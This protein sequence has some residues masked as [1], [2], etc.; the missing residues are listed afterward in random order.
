M[1][2]YGGRSS[3]RLFDLAR[4]AL[5]G[6]V[7]SPVRAFGPYPWFVHSAS[8]AEVKS[9]EG[10]EMVDFVLGYG[11]L[12]LGHARPEVV[13]A[14]AEQAKRGTLFGAP[15]EIE[16]EYAQ[17]IKSHVPGAERVRCV[18]T[19]AEAT[20]CALR[21]AR[22]AK[23]KDVIVKFDGGFHGAHDAVMVKGGSGMATHGVPTSK[24]VPKAVAALTRVIPSNDEA[25]LEEALKKE[26]VAAVIAEPVMANIGVVTP[27]P[28]FLKRLRAETRKRDAML[29]FDEVV[30]GFRLAMGGAQS[31]Y[32]VHADLVALG[33][34]AG[35]GLPIGVV[36][37]PEETMSLISPEGE[38][39]NAGTFNGNPLSMAAGLA[40]LKELEAG[41]VHPH[42]AKLT[43]QMARGLY[44][45][46][47]DRREEDERFEACVNAVTGMLTMF[48]AR[49]VK[50]A[51][52]ARAAD[53]KR[54]LAFHRAMI[55]EGFWLP[56]SQFEAW[57][58]SAAHT[59]DQVDRFC[60]VAGDH[61]GPGA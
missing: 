54:Y 47:D 13:E 56:P 28:G 26:D 3:K 61:I 14:I 41:R 29:V 36:A 35:G 18:N 8:G 17:T 53:A 60:E 39:Y 12:V 4:E 50:D 31:F 46:V 43:E 22:A 6:G 2:E 25:A 9:V 51:A 19:G 15:T 37:G 40:T 48:F 34:I 59:S 32:D 42:L 21:L 30:T 1:K 38:V 33:K 44:D 23:E 10:R 58:L 20:A 11:P 27:K 45:I 24:G 52:G 7:N 16:V 49:S 57:F 55:E 5:V